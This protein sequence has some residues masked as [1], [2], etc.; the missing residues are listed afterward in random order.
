MFIF[1]RFIK[2]IQSLIG[3]IAEA[4]REF[5]SEQIEQC[6]NHFGVT[7]GVGRVFLNIEFGFIIKDFIQN[8]SGISDGRGNDFR[9]VLRMLI[10]SP[11]VESQTAPVTEV[12]RQ[13]GCR[14]AFDRNRR[15]R[16]RDFLCKIS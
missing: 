13:R 14:Q 12:F 2:A 5:Q 7:G 8:I 15:C 6:E 11:S 4:R 3:N 9:A 16:A 10:G 1:D